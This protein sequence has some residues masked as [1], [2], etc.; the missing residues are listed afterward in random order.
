MTVRLKL[1][2]AFIAVVFVGNA[3]LSLFTVKHFGQVWLGEVQMRVRLDLNSARESYDNH[4]QGIVRFLEAVALDERI[5]AALRADD[6]WE[7]ER[8]LGLAYQR[9]GMDML[10]AVAPSG[11]VRLRVHSPGNRGDDVWAN[12]LISSAIKQGVPVWGTVVLSQRELEREGGDLA[13]R[14]RFALLP[15]P[16][17]KPTEEKSRTDGM[18][19]AAAI[20]IFDLEGELVGVLYGADLLNRRYEIVDRIK[21]EVFG[22]QVFEGREVGTVTIF[23][24]DLRVSTNVTHEDGTRAVGTRLSQAVYQKVLEQ[25]EVWEDRAFVV[26]AWYITAYEPIRDPTGR[27]IGALY[28]GQLEAPF[29]HEEQTIVGTFLLMMSLT[30][31]TSLVLL[32]FVT[33]L[34]LRPIGR[35]ITMSRKV[36]RGDMTAR[37]DMRPPGE[38]G[39]L[40]QAINAMADAVSLREAQ[41]KLATRKHIGRAEKLA[42]V[43]RL[44]AGIAHE[45]NN[46]L[47][48]ILT[49]AH[50][51][52]DKENM[53]EEDKSDLQVIISE[54]T[55]VSEIVSGLLDFARERPSRKELLDINEV[56][57][58]TLRLVSSQ[59][60][61]ERVT[62]RQ[63]LAPEL[64]CINGDANQLE[65][66]LLNLALNSIEAMP[67]G[68]IL[69]IATLARGSRVIIKVSD[70]GC[71]IK[72]EHLDE[73]FEPFFST[74][75]VGT[76]TGLGLSVS[77]G[78]IEQ[79][80]GNLEAESEEGKGTTMTIILPVAGDEGSGAD[81]GEVN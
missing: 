15:T 72:E 9:G 60:Q 25:G 76:G 41:L 21:A 67:G 44:S 47:T 43:G 57:E 46:P 52:R 80:G 3:L 2:M 35:I 5:G 73:V 39:R 12:P 48:G 55:R 23:Q 32:F 7:L 10:A 29:V 14:A 75:P 45:I 19:A 59:K 22:P 1:T 31:V 71:G 40:C 36:I 34:V 79:H 54:T 26:N 64:P 24:G 18:V 66:V 28:V 30:T 81:G 27:V 77:Y 42:S 20:P 56:V 11:Q 17:A 62:V 13:A 38:M 68:G 61:M 78:I 70:T 37:V 33:M 6:L 63:D 65:Q 51:L 8:R 74:K 69:S 53:T 58:R 4:I 49:F 50:L 16:A